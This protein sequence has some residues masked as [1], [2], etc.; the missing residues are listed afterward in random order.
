MKFYLIIWFSCFATITECQT[1]IIL[2]KTK[3]AIYVGAD[4]RVTINKTNILGKII[5]DTGSIC[6]IFRFGNHNFATI[7]FNVIKSRDYA[8]Q[9]INKDSSFNDIISDYINSYGHFLRDYLQN[10]HD[11]D[12]LYYTKIVKDNEPNI[13]Q[14]IFFGKEADTLFR[15]QV[16]FRIK[17]GN[18]YFQPIQIIYNT[19]Y[20]DL[21]YGGHIDEIEDTLEHSKIFK[22]E[23]LIPE[24]MEQLI[25]IEARYYPIEVGGEISI[26][27]LTKRKF[28]WIKRCRLCN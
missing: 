17:E 24:K 12:I 9:A 6:K 4:S 26:L 1:V 14:M 23:K 18:N 10:I 27:K 13:S 22:K 19:L 20:R 28:K 2:K 8:I 7:G 25:N 5:T 11:K 21:L 16:A 15:C 3:K